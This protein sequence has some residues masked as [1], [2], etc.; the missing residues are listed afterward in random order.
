MGPARQSPIYINSDYG[1]SRL[2]N[3]WISNPFFRIQ[4]RLLKKSS[5]FFGMLL[6]TKYL[7]LFE[8][9]NANTDIKTRKENGFKPNSRNQL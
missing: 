7:A 8:P 9:T 1:I 3:K 2:K 4:C 5:C 6:Y